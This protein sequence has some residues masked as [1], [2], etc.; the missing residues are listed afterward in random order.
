MEP[1][2]PVSTAQSMG[3]GQ[4]CGKGLTFM[5]LCTYQSCEKLNKVVFSLPGIC[6]GAGP[7]VLFFFVFR[8]RGWFK[9]STCRR[10]ALDPQM[11]C[12]GLAALGA[13][14]SCGLPLFL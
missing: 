2:G 13:R 14:S 10:M 11:V 3:S 4:L 5:C 6:G 8:D 9:L 1:S 12:R 7:A